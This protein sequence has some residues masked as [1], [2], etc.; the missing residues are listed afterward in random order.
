MGNSCSET[1][2]STV[3]F[4]ARAPA[5][6][7]AIRAREEASPPDV[8]IGTFS[9]FD[10][11]VSAFSDLGS[12]YSFVCRNLV[13]SKKLS[14]KS[15]EFVIK[16]TNPL[17][18]YVLVDKVCKI[19]PLMIRGCFPADLMLLPFDKFDMILGMDWLTLHD[20]VL[21]YK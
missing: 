12:T 5:R 2:D 19:R 7:Y 10:T 11:N 3:R 13:T 17:G 14:F 4:E 16:V 6:A 21:N 9:I 8:I 1:K 15:I 18:Q 20:A